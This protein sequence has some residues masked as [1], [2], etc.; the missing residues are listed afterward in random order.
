MADTRKELV[1]ELARVLAHGAAFGATKRR[2]I[3]EIIA[4]A[5]AGA[6]HD[7][8]SVATLA[9]ELKD[10]PELRRLLKLPDPGRA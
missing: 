8:K 3:E 5:R 4:R 6:F 1:D 2:R 10:S 9:A 7:Y